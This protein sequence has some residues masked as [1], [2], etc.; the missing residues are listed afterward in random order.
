MK[1][2]VLFSIVL[3]VS[4][5]FVAAQENRRIAKTGKIEYCEEY[6]LRR[7]PTKYVRE[8]LLTAIYKNNID[9]VRL[10]FQTTKLNPNFNSPFSDGTPLPPVMAAMPDANIEVIKEL[11]KAGLDVKSQGTKGAFYYAAQEGKMEIIKLLLEAGADIDGK[12]NSATPLLI[13]SVRDRHEVVD[14][15]LKSK[16]DVNAASDEG[17]TSLMGAADDAVPIKTLLKAGAMIDAVDREGWSALFFAVE[18]VQVDKLK[19][20]LENGANVDVKDKNG[21]TAFALAEKVKDAEK[22]SE[23]LNLLKKYGAK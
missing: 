3:A 4:A 20:L 12:M 2:L 21:Q 8:L 23:I 9:C 6:L 1:R 17:L 14:F 19:A 15:L 18:H 7:A 10:I 22:R 13:A 11:I 16:A 5:G